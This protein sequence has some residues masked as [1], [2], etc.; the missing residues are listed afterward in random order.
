[1]PGESNISW[2]TGRKKNK[3]LK[4]LI[5]VTGPAVRQ[6]CHELFCLIE[7]QDKQE[8]CHYRLT[9]TSCTIWTHSRMNMFL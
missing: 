3:L 7:L 9:A 4:L 6:L 8:Q 5:C 1:M 2:T